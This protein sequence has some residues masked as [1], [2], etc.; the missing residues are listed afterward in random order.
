MIPA[1]VERRQPS[2]VLKVIG[3]AENNLARIDVS[4]PLGVF[5]AV[6]GVSGAGKSSLVIGI[7]KPA[8]SA[9]L[10]HSKQKPGRFDRLEGAELLDKVIHVDQTSRTC[11][12]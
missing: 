9:L 12:T 5:T 6:T 8:L 7:L 11:S 2:G 10:Q 3:A 4:I 1:R